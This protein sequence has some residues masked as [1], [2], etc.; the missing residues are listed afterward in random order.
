MKHTGWGG[1]V[2]VLQKCSSNA[3]ITNWFGWSKI[4]LAGVSQCSFCLTSFFDLK[5]WLRPSSWRLNNYVWWYTNWLLGWM[6]LSLFWFCF[7]LCQ[8]IHVFGLC[9][10]VFSCCPCTSLLSVCVEEA[11]HL[12]WVRN[13]N[14]SWHCTADFCSAAYSVVNFFSSTFWKFL[15]SCFRIARERGRSFTAY[16]K[17]SRSQVT[18]LPCLCSFRSSLPRR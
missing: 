6:D 13:R 14:K 8:R 16:V 4:P 15:V 1:Y 3:R 9:W 5:Q 12:E 11:V 7:F 10:G 17:D 2:L 18:D